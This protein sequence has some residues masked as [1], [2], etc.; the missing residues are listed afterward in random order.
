[1]P[2]TFPEATLRSKRLILRPFTDTDIPDVQAACSDELTQRWL[3]LP[4]PYTLE[5][6]GWF[7][8]E[9]APRLRES[10]DG[11][12][13]AI[14]DPETGRLL[15]NICLK[16]TNWRSRVTEVGYWT[17]PWARGRGVASEA[18]RVVT[19]WALEDQGFQRVELLA[20]T[21]NAAS[22]KVAVNAGF[23]REGILR[24]SGITHSG[25]VD[26]VMFSKIPADL[27]DPG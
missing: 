1:M 8:R 4:D 6:A 19:D 21:G 26:L 14:A 18:A 13:F 24:N 15:G 25:R 20:A 23:R 17:A 3:P 22:G 2:D 27:E 11:I 7:C 9:H 12:Q 16:K 10:G 5:A